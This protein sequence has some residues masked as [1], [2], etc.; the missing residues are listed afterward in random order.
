MPLVDSRL[1]N[2]PDINDINIRGVCKALVILNSYVIQ[3]NGS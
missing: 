3:D 2:A 1:L